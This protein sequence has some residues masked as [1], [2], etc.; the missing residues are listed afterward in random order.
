LNGCAYQAQN[1]QNPIHQP[2]SGD[3]WHASQVRRI[4]LAAGAAAKHR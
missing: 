1:H 4:V 2:V 3:R